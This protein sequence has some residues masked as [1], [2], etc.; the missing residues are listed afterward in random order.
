MKA[1]TAALNKLYV[2][3]RLFSLYAPV[4]IAVIY[5]GLAVVSVQYDDITY[6]ESAHL[7]YGVQ[8]LKGNTS[9][10]TDPQRFRSTMPISAFNALPR[11]VEQLIHRGTKKTDWGA[12]D[13]KNGRYITIFATLVL[14]LY[15]F[16][17]SASLTSPPVATIVMALV[18][19]DPNVLAHARLVTTDVYATIGFIATLYHCWKWLEKKENN[20]F[21]YWCIVIAIA[22]C[23]KAN[24]I[25]LYPICFLIILV[26]A[27]QNSG[28]FSLRRFLPKLIIFVA[29]QLL[30]I[31]ACFLF[32][33]PWGCSL[34]QL[35]LSSNFFK[36]YQTGWLSKIPIPF[37]K[38]YITSFDLIQYERETFDGTAWNYLLGALRY[39]K[40]FWNYYLVCYV[41]KTPL[42]SILLTASGITYL[43][44]TKKIVGMLF[45]W[46]P[47]VVVFIFLSMSSIQ[48]G[49][50]YL[51]PV[52]CLFLVFSSFFLTYMAKKTVLLP[53]LLLLGSLA[54]AIAGFPNYLV[55]TN[56][57]VRDK[58]MAYRFLAD[59]NFNWGQRK[60]YLDAY[61]RTHPGYIFEPDGPVTGMIV[62]DVNNLTGITEPEKFKWLREKYTPVA[63]VQGCYLVYN[64]TR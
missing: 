56:V 15:C 52:N 35:P 25:L 6:D 22:Q 64:I 59:S 29:V 28:F 8:I 33:G 10:E 21:Y 47:G 58:K 23:C 57:L 3:R 54:T 27:L 41:L 38:T 53:L 43:F 14:L 18:A 55:Y 4:L 62:V 31:N 11:A 34:S 19:F 46:W 2:D 40:G 42:L 24:N 63:T 13:V 32:S 61:M 9:R 17:F 26:T 60:S 5:I 49:Y 12:A 30:I 51:L 39:K 20:H 7:R 44:I 48:N 16:L 45:G 36:S 50:R 1:I 37:S